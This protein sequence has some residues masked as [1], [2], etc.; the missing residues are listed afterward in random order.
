MSLTMFLNYLVLV[1][2]IGFLVSLLLPPA[3]EKLNSRFSYLVLSLHW[4]GFLVFT[5]LW[6]LQGFPDMDLRDFVVFRTSG[7]EFFID[8]YFDEVSA[9]YLFVGALL[10]FLITIYS[11]YYLH[12]EA[13]YKRF[14]NTILFFYLGYNI[15]VLSGNLETMFVGWEI[16]GMSSFLLIAFYRE[17]YLPVRN[18]VKVFT[19]YRIGDVGLIIAMWMSHHLW[20]ENTTFM[21]LH[22]YE[23]VHHQ[24]QSHSLLG[25]MV[26]LMI[27]MSA[28]VKSAQLPFSSWLPR[29]ME[30]P[31]PSSAIFYG[32]LSVHIGV[33]VLLRTFPFWEH[34]LSV[35][36]LIGMLGLLTAI[37]ATGIARVQSSIK[38][39]V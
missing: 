10:T 32:S 30:G 21:K 15:I 4:T 35:R 16:L 18:A 11:R 3:N 28:A 24:L 34:Q 17:R 37:A 7:Y 36:I 13:G 27:L 2:L 39:Q 5:L 20:H 6:A 8:F 14:F 1:P 38:S 12:R 33:F 25:I 29:A 19:V 9:V 31:T 23:L 26:S 22:N